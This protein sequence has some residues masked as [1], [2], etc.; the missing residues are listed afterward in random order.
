MVDRKPMIDTMNQEGNDDWRDPPPERIET[1]SQRSLPDF[2]I[3]GT[4]RGGTT[5]LYRYLSRHPDVGPAYRKEVHF[6]DRYY[7]K[8]LDWYLAHFPMRGEADIV[9]E[10][11]PYY[12]FHPEVPERI[13]AVLPHA[14]F[15]ALLR[16]P[17]DRAYSHYHMKVRR[18]IE[19]LSFEEAIDK[20]DERMSVTDDAASLPWRHYSYLRR[21]LYVDQL[22]RWTNIFPRERLLVI[23][24]EDLYK[25][26]ARV[27][28]Q[29]QAFL[30]LTPWYPRK[31]KISHLSEYDPIDPATRQRMTEYFAPH[32]QRLYD[33]LDTDLGWEYAEH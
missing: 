18:G 22:Q 15:I 9:G 5:S 27:L 19:T 32:N 26:P 13:H 3:I 14:K 33:F 25:D 10:A 21:G 30:G 20:E 7:A 23:K 24:S 1:A 2:A 8:G 29:T 11:S 17:V 4:Q 12:L 31:F 6:F 16:N 28:T